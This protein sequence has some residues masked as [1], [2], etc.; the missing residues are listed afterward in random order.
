M[1]KKRKKIDTSQLPLPFTE[2][3]ENSLK[4]VE[5]VFDEINHQSSPPKAMENFADACMEIA[6]AIKK[7]IKASG[8]SRNDVADRVNKYFSWPTSAEM[9][10][11]KKSGE[12][13]GRKHLSSHM[14]NHYLSKPVDYPIPAGILYAIQ[15]VTGSLA[16]CR[17]LAE[18][19]DA[20][21]ISRQEKDTLMVGRMY[22]AKMGI[23]RL[24]NEFKK[25]R[26]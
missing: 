10:L 19:E 17:S 20:E 13:K 21:V 2:R 4:D 1:A 24:M 16:V 8:L 15:G 6:S 7:S 9:E 12:D 25:K 23:S 26:R 18:A 3:V 14:F 11:L 22:D 5:N